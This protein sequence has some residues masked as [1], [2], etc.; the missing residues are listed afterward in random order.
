[1]LVASVLLLN[2]PPLLIRSAPRCAP[3]CCH[4]DATEFLEAQPPAVFRFGEGRR[5]V[6][7]EEEDVSEVAMLLTRCFY[8]EGDGGGGVPPYA[9]AELRRAV[10]REIR[11]ASPAL[12]ERWRT[13]SNGL[14]SRASAR[15]RRPSL[16]PSIDTTLML[17]LEEARPGGE[18]ELICCCELS[19]RPMDGRLPGELAPPPP[20]SVGFAP[21]A[22]P[23]YGAYLANLGVRPSHRRL[24]LA[25]RM[26]AA[27]EWIVREVWGL[28]ELYLHVDL[29]N[30]AAARLY[31]T[32]GYEQLPSFDD[33]CKP[34][35]SV[36]RRSG[37]PIHHRYHRK[38]W[39][40]V[41]RGAEPEE[42][43]YA[44][45]GRSR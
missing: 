26:L 36:A 10:P 25:R 23:A 13:A 8:E 38:R 16:R 32:M 15:L 45:V 34:L 43:E 35:N 5:L 44:R 30:D 41:R 39:R 1:M 19:L 27:C 22:R 20:L 24:G 37:R 3:P 2:P 33:V 11:G 42:Q 21:P 18:P 14:L 7:P 40:A 4:I 31:D 17:T 28:D 12:Q 6:L 9:L 29:Y